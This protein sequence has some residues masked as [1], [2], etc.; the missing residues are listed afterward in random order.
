PRSVARSWTSWRPP[1]SSAPP[2]PGGIAR[3]PLSRHAVAG[4]DHRPAKASIA[5]DAMR[6]I[7]VKQVKEIILV[8]DDVDA[9]RRLYRDGLGLTMPDPLDRLN[10]AAPQ[11]LGV[12]QRGVM[13]HP[14]FAGRVH[15]GLEVA[16]ADSRT[17]SITCGGRGSR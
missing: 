8:G 1:A 4:Y 17:L 16:A 3:R 11:Y 13:A 10:L 6:P 2:A 14:G 9:S 5:R 7:R 15:L 12:A